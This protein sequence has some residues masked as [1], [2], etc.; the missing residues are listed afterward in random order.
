MSP[1]SYLLLATLLRTALSQEQEEHDTDTVN[2]SHPNMQPSRTDWRGYH[3]VGVGG[4]D[5]AAPSPLLPDLSR[6]FVVYRS[7]VQKH[8]V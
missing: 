2:G 7:G 3:G 8:P 6:V 5:P 1:V 4:D